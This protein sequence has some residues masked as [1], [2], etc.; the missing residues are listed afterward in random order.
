MNAVVQQTGDDAEQR[1][2]FVS[3]H[4]TH[5]ENGEDSVCRLSSSQVI[6]MTQRQ[7]ATSTA[8]AQ[9]AAA[10]AEMESNGLGTGST[11]TMVAVSNP[12]RKMGATKN[13][14]TKRLSK[15]STIVVDS[16]GVEWR[17]LFDPITNNNYFAQVDDDS[18]VTWIDPS[19]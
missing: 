15:N 9:A 17:V 19:K 1:G 16:N 3:K 2:V 7:D 4:D 6:E 11:K 13:A 14:K 18:Q 5:K 12:M 10:T 8:A